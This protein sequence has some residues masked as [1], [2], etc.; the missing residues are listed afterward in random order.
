MSGSTGHANIALFIPHNGCPHRCAF[1]SQHAI[2]GAT[3]QPTAEDVHAAVGV[4]M[5]SPKYRSGE[6]E[7]AFFGG[8]FTAI[9]RG[10]MLSLLEAAAEYVRRGDV[11][12]IRISTRPDAVSPDVLALLKVCGVTAV[13]LGA[14]SMRDEVLCRNRRGHTSEDV[15][16][17]SR[18]IRQAGLSLG[19][20][21]MTGLD[22]DDDSGARE[23]A[24]ELAALEPDTLRIYPTVVLEGT[25]LADRM[26]R[27]E[28]RPQGVEEA[29]ELCADLLAF[30]ES[31]HIR[32]IKL[33]LHASDGVAGSMAG[34][35]YHPAFRELCEGILYYRRMRSLL[36][37]DYPE[38]GRF[39]ITVPP[40]DVSKAV[41]Q[42][43]R[44]LRR[45][46]EGG[47]QVRIQGGSLSD[48]ENTSPERGRVCRVEPV[49]EYGSAAPSGG[50][51][52][53][54]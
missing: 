5:A 32:V 12:G 18:M 33:G 20:Q 22:G 2:S 36:A 19:L 53:C 43:K 51:R 46:A 48:G 4:A 40:R 25:E 13:E 31:R 52:P 3:R 34:G 50:D 23:T 17:A 6:T 38:G 35:A 7:I 28:F 41:G 37:R 29:A 42:Q 10:Y 24:R 27:G 15:R 9:E 21:M 14:Q 44:N 16:R 8:S 47:W 45:L 1:C 39:V 26:R 30:F 49:S 54:D 11:A